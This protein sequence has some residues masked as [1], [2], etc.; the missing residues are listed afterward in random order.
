MSIA[1]I[2]NRVA[3]AVAWAVSLRHELVLHHLTIDECEQ[4]GLLEGSTERAIHWGPL[5]GASRWWVAAW[6]DR[7]LAMGAE[8][9]LQLR[10][11][12]HYVEVWYITPTRVVQVAQA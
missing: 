4:L 3:N 11:L 5:G 7:P 8:G 12:G 10:L 9:C 6:I 1:S 2:V